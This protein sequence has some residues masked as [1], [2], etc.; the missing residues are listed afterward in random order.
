MT[1][2]INNWTAYLNN[3]AIIT[4]N[5]QIND[6]IKWPHAHWTQEPNRLESAS[7]TTTHFQDCLVTNFSLSIQDIPFQETM[8]L[9]ELESI[10]IHI[11]LEQ[12]PEHMISY[13][14]YNDWWTR[15]YF[16]NSCADVPDRTNLIMIQSGNTYLG[17]LALAGHTFKAKFIPGR[18]DSSLTI[19]L[20]A[21]RSGYRT[22]NENFL[23]SYTDEDPYR[24]LEI[25]MKQAA[26][27]H[28]IPTKEGRTYP[29]MFY[30][31][32]WCSWDAFYQDI[33]E[34]KVI[35]KM[36]EIHDKDIPFGW[37]LLDDGWSDVENSRL[38]NMAADPVKFP[39]NLKSTVEKI[40]DM[41]PAKHVGVWHAFSGYWSGLEK[42][43][44]IYEQLKDF[45]I[46]TVQG[47]IIP[48]PEKE[49]AYHYFGDWH[50]YLSKQGIDFVKVDSQS[51]AIT[52]YRNNAPIGAS[53]AQLHQ[54][55]DQ[56]VIDYMN[57]NLINCMGMGVENV[58]GRPSSALSRNSDDFF[59]ERENSFEEHLL[60]NAYNSLYHTHIYHGDWDMFWS[61]HP[62]AQ[63]HAIIRALSG[64]PIY[65]SDKVGESKKDI[66]MKLC[67]EDGTILKANQPAVPTKDCIFQDPAICGYL[68]IKNTCNDVGYLAIFNYS[69]K[70]VTVPYTIGD[71]FQDCEHTNYAVYR[72][73]A[74]CGFTATASEALECIL[75]AKGFELFMISPITHGTCIFGADHKYLASHV[76]ESV[77]IADTISI[78]IKEMTPVLIYNEHSDKLISINGKNVANILSKGNSFYVID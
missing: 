59:P 20:S 33:T 30:H 3:E 34:E 37:I 15:P 10:H 25:L 29:E 70:E 60:Q 51:T 39:G 71:V 11:D 58:F 32:G 31:I 63:K 68:K 16:S 74:D 8:T 38:R 62:D 45:A 77:S 78:L 27:Y 73:F 35:A 44:E 12:K 67:Y 64:G 52:H 40:K 7:L 61:S 76:L 41:T 72:R 17:L 9:R 55:L 50:K 18:S 66:L 2:A 22:V 36:Q 65:V 75:P 6:E 5:T 43:S 14:M 49:K 24:C 46:E 42:G 26:A 4:Q 13:Y 19:S 56:A 28:N 53:V 1:Y 21:Y 69:D 47:K 57:G 54:G 48:A 23:I